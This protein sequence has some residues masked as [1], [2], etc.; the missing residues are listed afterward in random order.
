[1]STLDSRLDATQIWDDA[2]HL[3]ERAVNALVDGEL[4]V[5]PGAAE[6]ADVCERCADRVG[7]AALFSL[8]IADSI[9]PGVLTSVHLRQ[10]KPG[11]HTNR[12]FIPIALA[13]TLALIALSPRAASLV[14]Q[15]SDFPRLCEKVLPLLTHAIARLFG[16]AARSTGLHELG[17]IAASLLALFG[18]M[19]AHFA[20]RR[21]ARRSSR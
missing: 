7:A 5:V 9:P 21:A 18:A 19:V 12:P 13:L 14:A 16:G 1:M 11:Q 6:H 15:A 8:E 2:G 4:G 3:S 20:P 10:A 17:L